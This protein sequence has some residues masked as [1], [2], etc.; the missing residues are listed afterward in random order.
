MRTSDVVSCQSTPPVIHGTEILPTFDV[1]QEGMQCYASVHILPYTR[2]DRDVLLPTL[3]GC[4]VCGNA[5]RD[6]PPY[7]TH[8]PVACHESEPENEYSP[9]FKKL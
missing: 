3:H 7:G 6:A 4:R 9:K 1:T 2:Y 8:C 5:G